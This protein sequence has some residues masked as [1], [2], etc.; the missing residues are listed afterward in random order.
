MAWLPVPDL[1]DLP[2]IEDLL[3]NSRSDSIV[4]DSVA[5][6]SRDLA[7]P[8][9]AR[10]DPHDE[11]A[12][13]PIPDGDDL[14]TIEE[15]AAAAV[16]E[17]SAA[18]PR[19]RASRRHLLAR[20][21]FIVLAAATLFGL[22]FLASTLLDAGDDVTI[23]VDGRTVAI[24]TGAETVGGVLREKKI[25]V[26]RYDAVVP[27]VSTPIEND[28]TVKVV[29]AFPVA[30][31]FDGV[32]DTVFT[33]HSE[34]A[35]FLADA[36]RQL[37]LGEGVNFR[38]APTRINKNSELQLRTEKTG[39]LLV[40]GSAVNY[41]LP[42]LTVQ[43]LLDSSGIVLGPE[44]YTQPVAANSVLPNNE[45]ITVVRVAT[46]TVTVLEPY[47]IDAQRAPDSALPIGET[48][49][50]PA[51]DGV[52][53]ATYSVRNLDGKEAARSII[54][55]VPVKEAVPAITYY[56]TLADPR[57]D[58]IAECETGG[59]WGALGPTYQGGL[60]IYHQTWQGFGGRD[61]ANNAGHASRE[62]QI[63]VGERIRKRYGFT[64]WGCGRT[65]GYR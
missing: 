6:T 31:D 52:R 3:Q 55:S 46:N 44:D 12:W 1:E 54:S 22:Y 15:L 51:V 64:A 14:P 24:E 16:K 65:L 23:R 58:K 37:R 61:F 2:T 33:T 45:S 50:T 41:K 18:P 5:L 63:I 39:T 49:N 21:G 27:A 43:E 7:A 59:N 29:R 19:V 48:R 32:P 17:P 34:P 25:K 28:M 13:L 30:V 35:Q 11:M 42:A 40:D 9:P 53:R 8:S 60:G 57:W 47:S 4:T 26:G 10:A 36:R 20:S 56:G 62:E 38:A